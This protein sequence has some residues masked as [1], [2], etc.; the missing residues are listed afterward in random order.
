MQS[1]LVQAQID[2][3]QPVNVRTIIPASPNA[4]S[5]G[6]YVEFPVGHYTGVPNISI[7]L[8]T[9]SEGG[10]ILPISLSYHAG[11][12]K[13]EE[14]A[15]NAGLGWTLNAGGMI[16]RIVRGRPD[17]GDTWGFIGGQ[18]HA[19]DILENTMPQGKNNIKNID[20]SNNVVD[21]EPDLYVYNFC[22]YSG[23]FFMDES[24]QIFMR[25]LNNLAVT[26]IKPAAYIEGFII[27]TPD[28]IKYH[29]GKS[30]GLVVKET[31][32]VQSLCSRTYPTV[33]KGWNLVKIQHPGTGA[34]ISLQYQSFTYAYNVAP[35]ETRY[36]FISGEGVPVLPPT[37]KCSQTFTITAQRLSSI[38]YRT[39][40]VRFTYGAARE[41]LPQDVM[42]SRVTMTANGGGI[43]K[44]FYFHQSYF[45]GNNRLRLDSLSEALCQ[46]DFEVPPPI[47]CWKTHRFEYYQEENLPADRFSYAQDHWGYYN[48]ESG[49]TT[50]VPKNVYIPQG[51]DRSAKL[52]FAMANTLTRIV[53]PTGA[54]TE[55]EYERNV[56]YITTAPL[57]TTKHVSFSIYKQLTGSISETYS[58]K[59]HFTCRKVPGYSSTSVQM[60]LTADPPIMGSLANKGVEVSVKNRITGVSYRQFS[61]MLT[62]STL[63]LPDG[64]YE[65]EVRKIPGYN[66]NHFW[67][68]VGYDNAELSGSSAANQFVGGLRVK[69][70]RTYDY[71]TK[72]NEVKRFQYHRFADPG[73]TSGNVVSMPIYSFTQQFMDAECYLEAGGVQSWRVRG[74]TAANVMKGIS[75]MP[76]ATTGSAPVGYANVTV[77]HGT[78]GELGKTEYTFDNPA[79]FPDSGGDGFPFSPADNRER[80]RGRLRKM[81]VYAKDGTGFRKVRETEH[82]YRDTAFVT[83][84]GVKAAF[85]KHVKISSQDDCGLG[86]LIE[87]RQ[88]EQLDMEPFVTSTSFPALT[89]TYERQFDQ[90]TPGQY[91]QTESTFEY[92]SSR[93]LVRTTTVV[94][95]GESIVE[96]LRY[97]HHFAA[98]T[99]VT[100]ADELSKGIHKLKEMGVRN[101]VVE[102]IMTRKNGGVVKA[103]TA[104]LRTW[105]A[106]RPLPCRTYS[107][108]A[109]TSIPFSNIVNNA[110]VK[111]PLY[112][113]ETA[114]SAYD[115]NGNPLQVFTAKDGIPRS[116]VW[117][118]YNS[119]PVAEAQGAS[120]AQISFTSFEAD[121]QGGW[122]FPTTA[123]DPFDGFTGSK[124]F[125][126]DG[127]TITRNNLT[128]TTRYIVSGWSKG[129]CAVSVS[130]SVAAVTG[131]VAKG[132]QY[133]EKTITN[134]TA[135]S[136]TG[137]GRVD[138]LRIYP[139]EATMRSYT[140]KPLAGITSVAEARPYV[141]HNEFDAAG[142]LSG[143]LDMHGNYLSHSLAFIDPGVPP[144]P[145]PDWQNVTGSTRCRTWKNG[146]TTGS[147]E[148]LQR[149]MNF[150]S[151]T[152]LNER[153]VSL[154][155]TGVCPAL[156]DSPEGYKIIN[157]VSVKGD[158]YHI[159][160]VMLDA[161][162]RATYHYHWPEDDSYSGTYVEIV[163]VFLPI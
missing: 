77:L 74:R 95:N 117:D 39:G 20:L 86:D 157:G 143:N 116:Y 102:K 104:V 111:S 56:A 123:I 82:E 103:Q 32:Q 148:Q 100:G 90:L 66:V 57:S 63:N 35:E 149:D 43:A 11:G 155:Q 113:E 98:V 2:M 122:T 125:I 54:A 136:I 3:N 47:G 76:L 61:A 83:V 69:T 94:S 75:S 142:M 139:E 27:T 107:I 153:W 36:G 64:Y 16:T 37:R 30:E 29:F 118:Y 73:H 87:I 159:D 127:R 58:E 22:G 147:Q 151:T 121:G 4:A 134:V 31:T 6:K 50:L 71:A 72:T 105:H 146:N 135:I 19:T 115:V 60:A 133:W 97:P 42:L 7:P 132:W 62:P 41:D 38:H 93:Q 131:P 40:E 161:G 14:Q 145:Q 163:G 17:D 144:V 120:Y 114:I 138:E 51:A 52:P 81:T 5:L 70:M 8:Q 12:I 112:R 106:D 67:L 91:L 68:N 25:P 156:P 96:E 80:Y 78:D 1:L 10:I 34:Q 128:P 26:I 88:H 150:Y 53:F 24:K 23:E 79:N 140:H 49:N 65:L 92:D 162:Y 33:T 9:V 119:L 99:N 137:C 130:G 89:K 13:V 55:F 85:S 110:F 141:T 152:Y 160:G 126:L 129:T 124:S 28:G 108:P 18:Y 45:P 21:G 59:Y 109:A 15:S 44:T 46:P 154:G 101:E 48:G 84:R 158:K